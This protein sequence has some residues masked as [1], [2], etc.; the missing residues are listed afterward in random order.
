MEEEQKQE[1]ESFDEKR[2]KRYMELF[3]QKESR[4]LDDLLANEEE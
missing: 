4:Y 3:H 2:N 1:E